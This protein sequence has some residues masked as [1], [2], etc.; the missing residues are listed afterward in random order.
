MKTRGLLPIKTKKGGIIMQEAEVVEDNDED[1]GESDADDGAAQENGT[2]KQGCGERKGVTVLLT[3][4]DVKTVTGTTEGPR[5]PG[6]DNHL[7][8]DPQF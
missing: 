4:L 1:G 8:G 7:S 5:R 6:F 3:I 2:K